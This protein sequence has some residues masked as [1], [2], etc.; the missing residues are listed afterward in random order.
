MTGLLVIPL[1]AVGVLLYFAVPRGGTVTGYTS[2]LPGQRFVYQRT[3]TLPLLCVLPTTTIHWHGQKFVFALVRMAN[4]VCR[5]YI[6]QQPNYM[7]RLT[8]LGSTHRLTDTFG[9]GYV[10]WEPEPRDA[11]QMSG[12]LALWV[13]A[14]CRYRESG[15]FP[16]ARQAAE[17]LNRS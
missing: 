13:A 1:I 16:N 14:T 5:A 11:N 3:S 17:E 12:A 15:V 8:G 9:R 2:L 10:C 7:G 6:I 4:G